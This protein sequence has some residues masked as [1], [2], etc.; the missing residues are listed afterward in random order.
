MKFRKLIIISIV[1]FIGL[2]LFAEKRKI[3]K[4]IFKSGETPKWLWQAVETDSNYIW[5]KG[6]SHKYNRENYAREDAFNSALVLINNYLETL[7]KIDKKK[8]NIFASLNSEN[9]LKN[10]VIES[11]YIKKYQSTNN[12]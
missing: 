12:N 5:F 1:F 4:L 3:D 2:N 9:K 7:K 6:E 11:W 10:A 8:E